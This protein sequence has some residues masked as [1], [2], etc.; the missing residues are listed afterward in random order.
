[1]EPNTPAPPRHPVFGWIVL[2]ILLILAAGVWTYATP[3]YVRYFAGERTIF[4]DNSSSF[5]RRGAVPGRKPDELAVTFFDVKYGDAIFVQAPHNKISLIDG[6]EGQ[7]PESSEAPVYDWAYQ[8]YLPFL[9]E[10]GRFTFLNIISTTPYSHHM[11]V[12]ADLLANEKVKVE[13]VYWTGY[14]AEFSAHRRFRVYARKNANFQVLRNGDSINFGPGVKAKVLYANDRAK[15]RSRVSRVIYLKYGSRS[16]L[17]MSDLPREDEETLVLNWG[18]SLRTDVLK[19]GMHGSDGSTG[20]E[21]LRYSK[22]DQAVISVS[23]N[24]PLGGPNKRVIKN[25]KKVGATVH[26]TLDHGHVTF[27]TDG[28]SLRTRRKSFSFTGT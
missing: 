6:G 12:L 19:V 25:L 10:I 22:P 24:N 20:Y 5:S 11:G 7:Y 3:A 2:G 4:R 17:F 28:E 27:Y 13:N 21:L 16:F 14:E 15:M 18:K 8:L 1:M 26:K 23:K 9:N